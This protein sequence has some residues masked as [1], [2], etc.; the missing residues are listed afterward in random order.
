M[1]MRG[2]DWLNKMEYKHQVTFLKRLT[3]S[4]CEGSAAQGNHIDIYMYLASDWSDVSDFISEAFV[5]GNTPEGHEF[6]ARY[7]WELN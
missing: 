2:I 6:W 1:V 5:W 3:D 7:M 4:A